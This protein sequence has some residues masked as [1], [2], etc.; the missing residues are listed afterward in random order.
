MLKICQRESETAEEE[1]N[2]AIDSVVEIGLIE[3]K[4]VAPGDDSISVTVPIHPISILD[5]IES[6]FSSV[7][8]ELF[9]SIATLAADSHSDQDDKLAD[10]IEFKKFIYAEV[11]ELKSKVCSYTVSKAQPNPYPTDDA[12]LSEVSMR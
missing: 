11:F 12:P 10:Y 2:N 4:G 7:K 1:L 8:K 3:R 5:F 6:R 9:T